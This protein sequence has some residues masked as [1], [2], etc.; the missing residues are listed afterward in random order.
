MKVAQNKAMEKTKMQRTLE[1]LLHASSLRQQPVVFFKAVARVVRGVLF[2]SLGKRCSPKMC[3]LSNV[4]RE[5][6]SWI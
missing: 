3:S 1:L 4:V 2:P 5:M 6:Q